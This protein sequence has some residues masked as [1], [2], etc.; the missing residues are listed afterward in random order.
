M[1][2]LTAPLII[3][4]SC[5]DDDD[6]PSGVSFE[7]VS[8]NINESDGTLASFQTSNG[9]GIEKKVKVVFDRPM[10]ENAV[11]SYSVTGTANKKTVTNS[12]GNTS[13]YDYYLEGTNA[14]DTETLI[15]NKGDTEAYI[16]LTIFE[17]GEFEVDD[18]DASGNYIETIVL[19]LSSVVSG[20]ASFSV[21]SI[22]RTPLRLCRQTT[23]TLLLNK[24]A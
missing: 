2:L 19:T 13:G 14:K 24:E 4:M 6:P 20:P 9:G 5:G 11:I 1:L 17:D 12:S 7:L 23:S 15:I 10:A 18:E 8:E 3:V 16:T 21:W 22:L